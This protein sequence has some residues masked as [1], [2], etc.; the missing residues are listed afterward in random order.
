MAAAD[1]RVILGALAG[2]AVAGAAARDVLQ[3]EHAILRNFPLVGRHALSARVGRPGAAAVHRHVQRRGAAVLA[4]PAPLGVR[5]VEAPDQ[6]V[7]VRHR[8]RSRADRRPRRVQAVAVPA[9]PRPRR[10]SRARRRDYALPAAKV[11]GAAHGRR[12][13]VPAGLDGEHLGDE[14]RLAVARG[15][16]GAQPRRGARRLPA[17]H[18]RGRPRARAP[19]RRRARSSRSA[20][21]TSAAAT[22]T[23]ASRSSGCCERVG[24]APVRAIEIKLSQ[25]AKPGLGGLL[26]GAEGHRGDRAHPRRA[27]VIATARAR[28]RTPRSPTSTG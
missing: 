19:A 6:H 21:A 16:G 12:A 7:R 13:R 2:A 23:A 18:G 28:P 8:Q 25:G 1:R 5:V 9:R 20:R 14:L 4:R 11:L 22:S 15:R 17:E 10:A 3:R 27:R 24:E 26:P